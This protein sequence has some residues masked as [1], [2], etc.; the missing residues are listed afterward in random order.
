MVCDDA[1][2]P[3]EIIEDDECDV[4]FIPP[5]PTDSTLSSP[6]VIKGIWKGVKVPGIEVVN[7]QDLEKAIRQYKSRDV[8]EEVKSLVRFVQE[9]CSSGRGRGNSN[10]LTLN[11][12]VD[13]FLGSKSGKIQTG[14]FGKGAAYS[15]HNAERLFRKLVL[16]RILDEELY[17]TANDQAVAYMKTGERAQAVLNGFT[18]MQTQWLGVIHVL[19]PQQELPPPTPQLCSVGTTTCQSLSAEPDVL[20]QIDGVTEDKLEKY[21]AELI[22]VLQKYSEWTLPAD[23]TAQRSSVTNSNTTGNYDSDEEEEDSTRSTYF[24][25]NNQKNGTKRKTAPYFRKSKKR[26]TGGEGQQFRPRGGNNSKSSRNNASSKTFTEY[27]DDYNSGPRPSAVKR[28][29]FM[30][31]PMPRNNRQFLKPSF[32]FL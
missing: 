29:G 2:E 25:A 22:D 17:I 3:E 30:A 31:V 21:G 32:A 15:R 27:S 20:L 18:K 26:K 16:D 23:D 12:M 9:H 7:L 14:I 4:D 11:M 28:P 13:I 6:P 8:T 10:R 5:S 24:K 1:I 19:Q